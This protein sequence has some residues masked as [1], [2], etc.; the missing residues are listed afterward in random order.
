MFCQVTSGYEEEI[1]LS[2]EI[3][4]EYLGYAIHGC[5]RRML[6]NAGYRVMLLFGKL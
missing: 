2:C 5:I 3:A 6:P 4:K 1:G